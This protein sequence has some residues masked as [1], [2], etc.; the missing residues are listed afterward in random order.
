MIDFKNSI[1]K[2]RLTDSQTR[3]GV[4]QT[5]F[6]T[7]GRGFATSEIPD[8]ARRLIAA[9]PAVSIAAAFVVGGILGWLTSRR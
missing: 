3:T 9:S 6:Q 1:Q 2:S 8:R 7:E 5:S 4:N